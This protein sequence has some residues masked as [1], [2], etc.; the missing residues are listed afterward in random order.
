MKNPSVNRLVL[1]SASLQR[2]QLLL[3][4]GAKI[5]LVSPAN[6]DESLHSNEPPKYYVNRMAKEKTLA[7][8]RFE[9]ESYA[10]GADTVVIA[11]TKIFPKTE[12]NE[13]A[14]EYLQQL[15][16]RRHQVI[17]SIAVI[18]PFGKLSSR[19]VITRVKFKRLSNAELKTYLNTN[20]WKGR[21]GGY[22]IQG[23]GGSFIEWINGSYSNVV[24]LPL[25]ETKCT[26]EGLGWRWSP[27]IDSSFGGYDSKQGMKS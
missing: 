8:S 4:M 22:A 15:S 17:T 16:G 19:L 18:S 6:I 26:L 3:Q 1:A 20:E 12:N 25:Y 23:I 14:K 21:A 2:K 11:G 9:Q 27:K 5:D 24:G 10:L 7:I 13:T